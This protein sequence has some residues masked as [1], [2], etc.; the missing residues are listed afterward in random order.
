[1]P[2]ACD[3]VLARLRRIYAAINA[4]LEND[5]AAFPPIVK[6]DNAHVSVHQD[7]YGEL[8]PAELSNLAHIVIHNVASV[9]FLK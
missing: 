1:M 8:T 4:V 9:A 7:F 2:A 5:M 3:E 6:R